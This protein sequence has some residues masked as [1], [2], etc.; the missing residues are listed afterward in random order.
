MK[1]Y[2][3]EAPEPKKGQKASSGGIRE[4]GKLAS[5]FKNPIPYEEPIRSANDISKI[6]GAELIRREQARAGRNEV[7]MYLFSLVWQEIGEPLF[8]AGLRRLGDKIIDIFEGTSKRPTQ[9]VTSVNSVAI[10]VEANEIE[11]VY[12]DKIIRFPQNKAI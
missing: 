4:N 2:I 7:K 8:C 6:A 1:K 5:Q 10:D 3:V 11:T 12:D 9:C